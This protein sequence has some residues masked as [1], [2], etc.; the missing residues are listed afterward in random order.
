MKFL[1][2]SSN[3]VTWIILGTVFVGLIV[4]TLF[5]TQNMRAVVEQAE[6]ERLE[7]VADSHQKELNLLLDAY[8]G[9]ARLIVSRTRLRQILSGQASGLGEDE[10]SAMSAILVDAAAADGTVRS[11]ALAGL[12]GT[13]VA[14]TD[15][16]T[17]GH[18]A[19][20]LFG[21]SMDLA[22]QGQVEILESVPVGETVG[23]VANLPVPWESDLIGS[24]RIVFSSDA[25]DQAVLGTRFGETGEVVLGQRDGDGN[26]VFV[27]D[28]RAGA[29]GALSLLAPAERF[30]VPMIRA[31]RGEAIVMP[32]GSVDYDGTEVIAVTRYIPR[33]RWGLV[34]KIDRDEVVGKATDGQWIL[35]FV[36]LPVILLAA[37]AGSVVVRRLRAEHVN[38]ARTEASFT[39]MFA[40]SP[41]ATLMIGTDG[42]IAQANARAEMLFGFKPGKLVGKPVDDLVPMHQ[43]AGH[44]AMRQRYNAQP[45]AYNMGQAR[46]LKAQRL[47]GSE[48]PV[49][50]SLTPVQF[51][52]HTMIVA[53]VLDISARKDI[54]EL[55]RVKADLEAHAGEL[56]R[57][58]RELD[59]FAYIASHDLRAPLRGI[60]QLAQF[61]EE[62]AGDVLPAQSRQDLTLLRGRIM[63]LENLLHSLLAYSR[64]GRKEA[65]PT[66]V[67]LPPLIDELAEL[68][69]PAD[70]FSVSVP[71]NL[72]ALFAPQPA[73]EL[74]FRNVLMNAVKHH[75]KA[76]GRIVVEWGLDGDTLQIDVTD[77]GPGIPDD[78]A[79]KV[80]DLFQ[81][82]ERRDKVEGSGMGLSIVR[83]TLELYGGAVF[84]VPGRESGTTIRMIWPGAMKATTMAA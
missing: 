10:M 45:T 8:L 67:E 61:I 6:I 2:A 57:S 79:T 36:A 78:Y 35:L 9:K 53:S 84:V 59:Q 27:V 37:I 43:R 66:R 28:P 17:I 65:K 50:V 69:V 5:S 13:V 76:E 47:D 22:R 52:S 58:N 12:G 38:R 44:V 62:D 82:L 64:V 73:V 19:R 70:R 18:D 63:R 80:F 31:L 54:A 21:P 55:R 29:E 71:R 51:G 60:D 24:I 34:A 1:P 7:V 74:V 32:E 4:F 75:D 11:I 30:D 33:L 15:P 39:E 42:I 26:A 40:N 81:T 56:A 46:D 49:E 41:N 3:R 48:V 23:I 14:A 77:D 68:Y 20:A 16:E 83:K 72:P 25:F